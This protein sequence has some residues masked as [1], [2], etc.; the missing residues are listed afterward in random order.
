M[1]SCFPVLKAIDAPEDLGQEVS[2]EWKDYE[3]F[4]MAMKVMWFHP[5]NNE[6][7]K[8]KIIKKFI[9]RIEIDVDKIFIDY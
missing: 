4:M 6:Q 2:V 3:Q 5:E 7:L 8:E 1:A 9:A